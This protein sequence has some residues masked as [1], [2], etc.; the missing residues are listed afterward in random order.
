LISLSSIDK[1]QHSLQNKG[2]KGLGIH[3][4]KN[5]NNWKLINFKF[6]LNIIRVNLLLIVHVTFKMTQLY[7]WH[8]LYGG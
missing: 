3:R 8:A 7:S 1:L 2:N 4:R 5:K 6:Y